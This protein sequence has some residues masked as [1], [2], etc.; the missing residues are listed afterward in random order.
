[1]AVA[2][3]LGATSMSDIAVLAHLAP[4]LGTAPSGPTIR[5]ALDPAD[6]PTMLDRIARARARARAH[7]WTP[8]GF[9]WLAIAGEVPDRVAGHRHGRHAGH[10]TVT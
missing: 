9:P 8:A 5:R 6:T 7:V 1:M 10:R 2:I 4:V 3:P